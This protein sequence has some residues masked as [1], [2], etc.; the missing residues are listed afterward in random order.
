MN[1]EEDGIALCWNMKG[2]WI[3]SESNEAREAALSHWPREAA[4]R[5]RDTDSFLAHWKVS[6]DATLPCHVCEYPLAEGQGTGNEASATP[7]GSGEE[8]K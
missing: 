4:Y 2:K 8:K 3:D 6:N 1:G 5:R 7:Q